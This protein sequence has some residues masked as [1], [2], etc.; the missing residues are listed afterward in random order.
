[1]PIITFLSDFGYKDHYVASVKARILS[2]QPTA[3]IVDISHAVQPFDIAHAVFVLSAVFRDFPEGTV[4]LV[5][6]DT[7]NSK[8]GKYHAAS[9]KGHYFLAADNGIISLLTDSEPD[10]LVEIATGAPTA[11]PAR[12]WLAPAALHL[13][14]GGSLEDLGPQTTQMRQ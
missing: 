9:Y 6:V 7:Q 12:D 10:E 4:H 13:A 5:A 2:S 14:N 3:A 8:S 1:M 11:A